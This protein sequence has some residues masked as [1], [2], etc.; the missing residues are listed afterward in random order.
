[1][2]NSF[3]DQIAKL[4]YDNLVEEGSDISITDTLFVFPNRRAGLFFRKAFIQL[5]TKTIFAPNISDIN[6]LCQ[7]ISELQ[8]CN[9]I[10][11]L[12]RLYNS[13]E[14]IYDTQ[15]EHE[16]SKLTFDNFI[17]Q[18]F[19]ILHDFDEI[20]KYL[21]D[22]KLLYNNIKDL[23]HLKVDP[24]YFTDEQ[25][26]AIDSFWKNTLI[27]DND[28]SLKFQSNF[29]SFW[30]SLYPLYCD[31]TEKLKND[32]LGYMGMIYRNVVENHITAP[33]FNLKYKRIVFIGFNILTTSESKLLKFFE[34]NGIGDF[35]FDYPTQYGKGSPFAQ[36]VGAQYAENLSTFHS[37][38]PYAQPDI[39]QCAR[40]N[41][42]GATSAIEQC[43][44]AAKII[45]HQ[46]N[47]IKDTEAAEMSISK[48][49]S[50]STSL[51]LADESILNS[52]LQTLPDYIRQINVTMG[53]PLSQ[54]L[55]A[56]LIDNIINL[57]TEKAI[58]G[59]QQTTFY[60]KPL[61]NILSH[62][63]IQHSFQ[64]DTYFILRYITTNNY[65]RISENALQN[66][67]A[68]IENDTTKKFFSTLFTSK[69]NANEIIEYLN[70][71]L[72][73]ILQTYKNRSIKTYTTQQ[74]ETEYI[75]QY[76]K[77]LLQLSNILQ[78]AKAN[79][80]IKTFDQLIKRLSS[81]LKVQFKGEP[82][83]GFQIMGMLESRLL[84][85]ENIII[86]GFND[87]FM[88]GIKQNQSIIPYN[89]RK[90]YNLPTYEKADTAFAYNFY[91]MLYRAKNVSLIYNAKDTN[92]NN[93]ISR[94]FYQ[95]K[96]LM[97]IVN[98]DVIIIHKKP[99][100]QIVQ[101][102]TIENK[103][104]IERTD[105]I[106][107]K[108][109]TYKN[110]N[111]IS[112][113]TLKS[114]IACPLKFYFSHILKIRDAKEI[115]ETNNA[116]LLGSIFH[117]AMEIYY[118]PHNT[119][120]NDVALLVKQAF[121]EIKSNEIKGLEL[122]GFN[123]LIYNVV[124]NLVENAIKFDSDREFE[125]IGSE[126]KFTTKYRDLNLIAII[127]RIDK[128][129]TTNC[130]N[131]IDYKTTKSQNDKHK[132]HLID[133]INSTDS[134]NHEI[135]QILL[136]CYI[137]ETSEK[138]PAQ[139]IIPSIYN[140]Y[141]IVQFN[142]S[143][144]SELSDL[145]K[146]KIEIPESLIS[147]NII[148]ETDLTPEKIDDLREEKTETIT[149]NNYADIKPYFEIMLDYLYNQIFNEPTKFTS[150]PND[151]YYTNCRFCPYIKVCQNE[152][153]IQKFR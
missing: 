60:H 79:I 69:N 136:Y 38:Y 77:Y 66:E 111:A 103:I 62:P 84:D 29:V 87:S 4:Y 88:P 33:S 36:T 102:T 90:A 17:N 30:N 53:Y 146:I 58:N 47:A 43:E 117:K 64:E 59:Q 141:E 48:I 93:E 95:L 99:K 67:I 140:L 23:Q 55:I 132:Y 135:F 120:T 92:A 21:V 37:K 63:Y 3:I 20:D 70:D 143:K 12:V 31:F 114:Y 78:R 82:L 126:K 134:A 96:H 118:S 65:I 145:L 109:N 11:L 61:I 129:P 81:G 123:H 142:K 139:K 127:D 28:E 35:Y 1:M 83:N 85:Y 80:D 10:E 124:C 72:N 50:D 108:I 153:K 100:S 52:T 125:Y 91:R 75:I 44:I 25:K 22:A 54:S 40:I 13:Y 113:S 89:L 147:E 131:I 14:Y 104:V 5:A 46:Y 86:I 51:V 128:D 130:I 27:T 119:K 9:D 19:S 97:P 101:N 106:Y 42:Y 152:D 138:Y 151:K 115:E 110:N 133:L 68:K 76:S 26:A 49:L 15:Y 137:Y 34:K 16:T 57:Q 74:F 32:G 105:E 73:F 41:I 122:D 94:Y 56:T 148:Q 45:H 39:T 150:N 116:P 71:I 107:D 2:K 98:S 24:N 121:D 112:A 18:G 8:L 144:N 7:S 149:I 6:S